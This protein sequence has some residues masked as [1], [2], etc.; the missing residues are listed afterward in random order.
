[1]KGSSS[2][3]PI[4]DVKLEDEIKVDAI[5]LEH[6]DSK[7]DPMNTG[8]KWYLPDEKAY[9]E[10]HRLNETKWTISGHD[11]QVLSASIPPG[12]TISTEVG[13][14]LFSHPDM[15]LDVDCTLCQGSTGCQ[16]MCGGESCV[17]VRS[18]LRNR[19]VFTETLLC[20]NSVLR[21]AQQHI[22]AYTFLG[23]Y[24]Q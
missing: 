1:M 19:I 2:Y 14:M 16:R 17:K 4:P 3:E 6:D 7:I 9:E 12:D 8:F 24:D 13:S 20:R 22:P 21:V 15:K 18:Y 5:P 10:D 23:G 11:M